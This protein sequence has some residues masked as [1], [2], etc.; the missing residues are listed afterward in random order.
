MKPAELG[1][2]PSKSV[3]EFMKKDLIKPLQRKEMY[4]KI[5]RPLIKTWALNTNKNC[6]IREN[7]PK[8]QQ[9]KNYYFYKITKEDKEKYN[10]YFLPTDHLAI[11]YPDK[12][13]LENK[14]Y[15]FLEMKAKY[16][17]I[18]CTKNSWEPS[19]NQLTMT[20]NSSVPY[21]IINNEKNETYLRPSASM[22]KLNFKKI[23]VG[24]YMDIIHPFYPNF[25]KEYH[26]AFSDNKNIFKAYK[27]LFSKMYDDATRNGNIY[28]PFDKKKVSS[29]D[30]KSTIL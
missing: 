11:R 14:R 26:Q 5:D 8:M 27:G 25:N 9:F 24:H 1:L 10:R 23:G 22:K 3:E 4:K 12:K 29:M 6:P 18:S 16:N 7:L 19:T 21:N 2:C 15:P 20:N 17:P 13:M 30:S 28:M